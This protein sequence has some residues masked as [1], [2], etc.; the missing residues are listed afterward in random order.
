MSPDTSQVLFRREYEEELESWLRRRFEFFVVACAVL[1]C[2]LA[3]T[4][5]L[6]LAAGGI[7]GPVL[8]AVEGSLGLGIAAFFFLRRGRLTRR[9]DLL[10]AASQMILALGVVSLAGRM[11]ATWAGHDAGP[12]TLFAIF[13]WHFTACLF[14]P[15]KPK[16]SVRPILP[17][18][19][20]W[21]GHTLVTADGGLIARVAAVLFSPGVLVPGLLICGWRL[22]RHSRR[23]RSVMLGRHFQTLRQEFSRARTI[24]ETL[25]PAS[26]DDGFVRVGHDYRPMRELGGD[27]LHVNAGANGVVTVAMMDVTGHG[28]PA[29]LTV[30]RISGEIERIWAE[31]PATSPADL[32]TLLNRYVGL[33]LA[34]HNIFATAIALRLDPYVGE[35]VWASAGHPP[36]LLR[37]ANRRVRGLPSTGLLLGAVGHDEYEIQE[38]QVELVPGDTVVAYTDGAYEAR[39]RTGRPFGLERLR[40]LLREPTP[41][42]GWPQ[43]VCGT[44]ESYRGGRAEDDLLVASVD[45]AAYRRQVGPRKPALVA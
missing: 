9:D 11:G 4:G 24:H 44:V 12:S 21:V 40:H 19:A 18:L 29:A 27:F 8:L 39:D 36:A 13:F 33:T 30:N 37:G 15:W 16:D 6:R 42:D 20:V 1:A 32:L 17:L 31:D 41:R 43:S 28:L 22:R 3:L 26:Y 23:F 7:W 38:R 14:L 2:G 25:F 35:L 5:L 34:R 45:F 10:H